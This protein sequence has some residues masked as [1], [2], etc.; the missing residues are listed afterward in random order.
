MKTMKKVFALALAVMLVVAITVPAAAAD[1]EEATYTITVQGNAS[2]HI[3]EAY[4]IFSGTL[5]SAGVLTGVEWGSGIDVSQ[6]ADLLTE[7]QKLSRYQN[8]TDAASVAKALDNGS[9]A[10]GLEF[11][12][13]VGK[14]LSGTKAVTTKADGT[15][16]DGP[17]YTLSGLETGYYLIKDRDGSLSGKLDESYTEFIMSLSKNTTVNPKSGQPTIHKK[18]SETGVSGTYDDWVTQSIG[19]QVHFDIRGTLSNELHYY[20]TY[21]YAFHDTMSQGL[22]YVEDSVSVTRIDADGHTN[23]ID[24][25]CYTVSVNIENNETKLTVTF[26]D[27]LSATSGGDKLT[28]NRSDMIRLHYI[29]Q[30][31][32]NTQIGIANPDTN[33]VQLEYSN[34]PNTEDHGFT[35]EV[36]VDIY[37]FGLEVLKVDAMNSEKTLPG[38]TFIL[39][40]TISGVTTYAKA[41]Q[42]ENGIYKIS[43]WVAAEDDATPFVTGAD[44]KLLVSGVKAGGF[45]VKEIAAPSGYNPLEEP[46][47]VWIQVQGDNLSNTDPKDDVTASVGNA[48]VE[49]NPSSGVVHATIENASGTVLPST[50]GMGTTIIYAIGGILFCVA[51]IMLVTK[52]R[53]ENR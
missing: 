50:G 35:H 4:Q 28:I 39:Y 38:A 23:V 36:D 33:A 26:A 32:Q 53:M 27:L 44:G 3:Y 2:G 1:G 46:L 21:Y 51:L 20:D 48:R 45:Y 30:L 41:T 29:A 15:Y 52:K 43:Q 19:S 11:A 22:T 7:L 17:A 18:V 25:S 6:E 31:N 10:D 34:N 40:R 13:I 8:A 47:E 42:Q 9:S 24:P 14:F 16:Q 37:T 49:V 12:A 5:D